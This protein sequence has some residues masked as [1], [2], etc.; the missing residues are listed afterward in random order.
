MKMSQKNI[1]KSIKGMYELLSQAYRGN[2]QYRGRDT[3]Y[4][5]Q[6]FKEGKTESIVGHVWGTMEFWFLLRRICPK[7]D[8]LL[9]SLEL[10]EILLNHDL[11]ETDKGDVPLY[12]KIKGVVDDKKA[13]RRGIEKLSGE[14][15]QIKREL[16]GWF[17]E[18]EAEVKKI[19]KLEILVARWIDNLQ[20]NHFA[21]TFGKNLPKF[22]KEI[23]SILHI[24]FVPYTNR[25]IQVLTERGEKEAVEEVKQIAREHVKFIKAAGI[26]FDTRVLPN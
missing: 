14:L 25:L 13:E 23:N 17:D 20:G 26:N 2:W 22:S 3:P 1:E 9:D 6:A 11:G 7:L 18:F 12:K 19:E 8:S 15:P 4:Y 21:L 16:L 10:Y 5:K 24:R